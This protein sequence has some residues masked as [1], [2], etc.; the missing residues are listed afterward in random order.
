M[1]SKNNVGLLMFNLLPIF[2][3]KHQWTFIEQR[4][5]IKN[6]DSIGKFKKISKLP[7]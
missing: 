3:I 4:K 5:E 6:N 2:L 1:K 7:W